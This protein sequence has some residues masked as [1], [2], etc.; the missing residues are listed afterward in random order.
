MEQGYKK[1]IALSI[2]GV[3]LFII[4]IVSVSYA[5]YTTTIKKENPGN[6]TTKIG[7]ANISAT[8]VDGPAI[9]KSNMVPGD[10]FEKSFTLTNTGNVPINFKIVVKE[11]TNEVMN[12]FS[13]PNDIEVV[14]KEGDTIKNTTTFP[15]TT[16]S[17][18]GTLTL[19]VSNNP[20]TYK[21]II[22]YKNTSADQ[23]PDMGAEIRGKIFIEEV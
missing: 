23:T 6:E 18:S 8:F 7:T 14:V 2:L 4:A 13:S 16:G 10:T 17:I 20:V 3:A 11:V 5:Y 15:T 12:T 22:H 21:V 9:N 19:P 1:T